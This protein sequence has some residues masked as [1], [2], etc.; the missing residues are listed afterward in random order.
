MTVKIE[1]D[2]NADMG[3]L[4]LTNEEIKQTVCY[5]DINLDL[6]S[7]GHV[8][9]IEFFQFSKISSLFDIPEDKED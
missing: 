2:E 9:G 4:K 7:D 5:G 8:V 3:Y 6:D 1:F